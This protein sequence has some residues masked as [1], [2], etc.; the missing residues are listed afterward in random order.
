[1]NQEEIQE[2]AERNNLDVRVIAG[3][4]AH[5][6]RLI[7]G[8][9]EYVLDIYIKLNKR[10]NIDSNSV[11]IWENKSWHKITTKGELQKL[12]EQSTSNK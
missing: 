10:R 8:F 1:M 2:W 7:D 5:H 4:P 6:F 11:L 3:N 12:Y 9:G